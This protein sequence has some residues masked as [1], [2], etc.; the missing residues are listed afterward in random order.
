[1]IGGKSSTGGGKITGRTDGE[2]VDWSIGGSFVSSGGG[3][4]G[5]VWSGGS[6]GGVS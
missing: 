2:G 5:V 1:M 3:N 4:S 6:I